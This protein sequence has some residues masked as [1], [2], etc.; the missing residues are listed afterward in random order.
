MK[1]KLI[2]AIA[3]ILA[4]TLILSGC[5]TS[6][7]AEAAIPA[8]SGYSV[9]R[10][11]AVE[12]GAGY[13]G[14]NGKARG[15]YAENGNPANCSAAYGSTAAAD[16]DYALTEAEQ[17]LSLSGYGSD[18]A[19]KDEDLTLADMLTYAIQDE[20]L[21]RAEYERITDKFGRV[22]PFTSS[23]RAEE[24]HIDALLPLFA[25]YG[26]AAPKDESAGRAASVS[27]LAEAYQAGVNAEGTNI[28]MYEIFL[29]KELPANVQAVFERLLNAS[30]NHLRAFQNRL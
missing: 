13:R 16:P 24:T 2:I 1:Q 10:V 11:G 7:A 26:I 14:G 6:A 29:A 3:A 25:A 21:A 12:T 30:E 5:V 8:G 4:C 18:G 27:S 19:L 23:M 15:G 22:R 28:A 17:T 20:F 9:A